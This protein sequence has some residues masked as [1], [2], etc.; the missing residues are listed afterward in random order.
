M[1]EKLALIVVGA[2]VNALFGTNG[3]VPFVVPIKLNVVTVVDEVPFLNLENPLTFVITDPATVNE[4]GLVGLFTEVM[5]PLNALTLTA[6]RGVSSVVFKK[7]AGI[8]FAE[9][10]I[11]TLRPIFVP[12]IG[13]VTVWLKLGDAANSIVDALKQTDKA[14]SFFI[15]FRSS[16]NLKGGK[17]YNS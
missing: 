13:T 15:I 5:L 8:A 17:N 16:R 4:P 7:E 3:A 2:L 14:T 12:V 9:L 1:V 6:P 11:L 10:V